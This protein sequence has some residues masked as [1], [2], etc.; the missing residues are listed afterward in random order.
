MPNS[1]TSASRST[2]TGISGSSAK[3][4]IITST[5]PASGNMARSRL[6]AAKRSEKLELA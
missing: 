5:H 2:L 4:A 6:A 1:G 3:R